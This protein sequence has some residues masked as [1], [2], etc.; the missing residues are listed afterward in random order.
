[1]KHPDEPPGVWDSKRNVNLFVRTFY[2][3]CALLVLFE[4]VVHRHITHSWER[5]FGFHAWYG[6]AACWILVVLA[7]QMRRAL[8]RAEDYYD[9]D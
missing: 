4:L 5:W 6:F 7:K 2:V 1:M 3:L 8:M 9:V